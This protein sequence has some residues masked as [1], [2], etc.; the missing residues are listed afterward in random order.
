MRRQD[1]PR[2][3]TDDAP[4]LPGDWGSLEKERARVRDARPQQSPY[5]LAWSLVGEFVDWMR[6]REDEPDEITAT[7]RTVR[8]M[9]K[10][11]DEELD[12]SDPL[13]W[14]EEMVVQLVTEIFPRR[15]PEGLNDPE[16]AAQD[17]L[18]FVTFL[19]ETG[20][21]PES[22]LGASEATLLLLTLA[23]PVP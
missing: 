9:L 23:Y 4:I 12:S 1:G 7:A 18:H 17:L 8:E 19:D 16:V 13:D 21:W 14:S 5:D 10:F 11:K 15:K 20:R 22:P 2:G 6:R 3:P